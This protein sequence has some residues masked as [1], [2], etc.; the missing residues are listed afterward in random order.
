MAGELIFNN[1]KNR[2]IGLVTRDTKLLGL[3]PNQA[4]DLASDVLRKAGVEIFYNT[5]WTEKFNKDHGYEFT[6]HCTGQTY[7]SDF[8][9]QNFPSSISQRG[10]IYVND[11]M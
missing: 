6:I 7:N 10:Q 8:L 9:K 5:S 3:L 11:F 1:P 4:H 2:K